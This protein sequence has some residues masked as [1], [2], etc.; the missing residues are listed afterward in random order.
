MKKELY[1]D[2][3]LTPADVQS[4]ELNNICIVVDVRASSTIVTLLSKGCKRVYTVETISDARS[5]RSRKGCC[6]LGSAM[7]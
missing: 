5:W 3:V 1:I 2:A 6:W 4:A 7:G